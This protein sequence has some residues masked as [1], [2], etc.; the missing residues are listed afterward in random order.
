METNELGKSGPN[1][2]RLGFGGAPAG[3]TDYLSEY[4]PADTAACK[5]IIAA[6]HRAVELDITYF[7]TAVDYSVGALIWQDGIFLETKFLETPLGT[8]VN[9]LRSCFHALTGPRS[10]SCS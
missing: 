8:F 6:I 3:L 2:S 7:D 9:R 1:V 10:H 5:R 4:F